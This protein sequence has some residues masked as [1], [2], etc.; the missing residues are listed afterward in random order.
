MKSFLESVEGLSSL[1][2][3][4]IDILLDDPGDFLKNQAYSEMQLLKGELGHTKPRFA[5]FNEKVRELSLLS[6][7]RL[8]WRKSL[9]RLRL[10]L[11]S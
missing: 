1:D 7:R 4:P 9:I 5:G 11:P 3:F 10:T 2:E 8:T 6:C